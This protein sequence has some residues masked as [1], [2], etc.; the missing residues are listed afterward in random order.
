MALPSSMKS[1]GFAGDLMLARSSYN[2]IVS[3]QEFDP[4]EDWIKR[5]RMGKQA[6]QG[7]YYTPEANAS[8]HIAG[9]LKMAQI[10][11]PTSTMAISMTKSGASLPNLTQDESDWNRKTF[12]FENRHGTAFLPWD[13]RQTMPAVTTVLR[14]RTTAAVGL[15]RRSESNGRMAIPEIFRKS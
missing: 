5:T 14:P 9:T 3:K 10:A 15:E 7:T 2:A 8:R 4:P 11:P 12:A 6:M 1:S 13:A